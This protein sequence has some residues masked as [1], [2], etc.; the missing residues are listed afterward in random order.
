M[1]LLLCVETATEVCAVGIYKVD[2]LLADALLHEG[3]LHANMLTTLI[4]QA[5]TQ[6]NVTLAQIDAVAISKGPGSY[7]GLRVG[8]ATAKGI[9]VALNKPLIGVA[10]LKALAQGY[11]LKNPSYTGLICPM[12]D[13]RRMEVYSAIFN[14]QLAEVLPTEARIIT[15]QSFA[16]K[17]KNNQVVFIGNGA[18][19]CASILTSANALFDTNVL[20]HVNGMAPIALQQFNNN[21]FEDLAYFEPFYLKE[22]VGT[23]PKNKA[24]H[25]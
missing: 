9:C 4:Q 25:P 11:M 17:L 8:L 2:V 1:P 21:L 22:F 10:T 19:K 15:E 20:C 14:P 13:A 18:Q 23:T 5:C 12:I 24:L 16:E 3:N 7:T 6:A